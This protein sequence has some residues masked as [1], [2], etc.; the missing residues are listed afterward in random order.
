MKRI[1]IIVILLSLAGFASAQETYSIDIL[2][3]VNVA[4][5][6][7]GRQLAN[8]AVCTRFS[9][10]SS[11]TQAQACTASFEATGQPAT[12]GACTAQEAQAASVRIYPN[13]LNGREAFITQE[14]I[15]SQLDV[16]ARQKAKLDFA[17][18][19]SFCKVATQPQIDGVC[20]ATGLEAGCSV[21]E[22]WR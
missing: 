6:D 18:M 3:P 2:S 1:Q 22:S 5:L 21:C 12:G 17:A 19:Q 11:C 15:R 8:Q 4:K 13:S 14:L 10:P 7:V 20:T 16:F 9:L